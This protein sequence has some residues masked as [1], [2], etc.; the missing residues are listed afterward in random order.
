MDNTSVID[1]FQTVPHCSKCGSDDLRMPEGITGQDD[2]ADDSLIT[3]ANCGT[4]TTYAALVE[5]CEADI[6]KNV[7]D[8]LGGL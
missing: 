8:T 5:C 3:C 1:T 4:V 7:K 2:L 6:V